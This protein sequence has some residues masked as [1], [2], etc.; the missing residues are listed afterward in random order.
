M[1]PI[2][3]VKGVEENDFTFISSQ[4]LKNGDFVAY[5]DFCDQPRAPVEGSA[6]ESAYLSEGD[7]RVDGRKTLHR[8]RRPGA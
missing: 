8:V 2:G 1:K 7:C 3:T 5:Q 6:A 4:K